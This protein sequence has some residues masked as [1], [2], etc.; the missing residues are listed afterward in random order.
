MM[1]ATSLGHAGILIESE[2]GSILCDPWFVPAFFGSWFPFP[3][4]DQLHD[5]LLAR[6]ERADYL[7]VSHLHGDHW[8]EPWLREHLPR[9]IGVLL[10]GYPTRE[11]DR[12]MRGPR[13]HQ[14]DPHHRRGGARPRRPHAWPSTSRRAS[15]TVRAATRPS[16]SATATCASSTRTTAARPT[17]RPC[18]ATVPSTSTGCSTAGRSGTR[19]C[20]SCPPGELQP[21]VRA[22]IDS[23]LA[24]AMRYVESVG[25]RAVVPSAGPPCF[26]DPEL[27]HLNVIDGDEPSIFCDQRTFL[28]RLA[29]SGHHG[30]LA[31]PGT[32]IEVA[33]V[34]IAV[35]HPFAQADVDA[36]FTDKGAYLRR[37]QTDWSPWLAG[38]KAS[39]PH[40]TDTDL[41]RHAAGVVGAA[42][43]DGPDRAWRHRGVVP[44][45]HRR[46]RRGARSTSRPARCG[47]TPA[48][49]TTSASTSTAR[50][51]RRSSPSGRSTGATRCSCR[52][53]SAPG[54]TAS[55]TSGSTTS[56]SRCRRS[57]CGA[58]R[59][60]RSAGST[61]RR[62]PNPTSSST[63]G[64]SSGAA[65]TATPTWRCSARSTGA[66]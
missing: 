28:D 53:A 66:R 55:S 54:A 59:P 46:R 7:Y 20:T 64:S 3:R 24:R 1:R 35:R 45:A 4:N 23:Q 10:P 49:S 9:D 14:P 47:P 2:H 15:P 44:A 52:A 5:D 41:A 18:A 29:R 63:A 25:A 57:A 51:S 11:L 58:P 8:D 6:I 22:K 65:R 60:R 16:S 40:D 27:F 32:A 37:Y 62:R 26:L 50:S 21:L 34:D 48:M 12:K 61:R 17:S 36:I 38:I 56:S 31:V 33:P 42:A 30:I 43:G 39:W 13:V 19:W